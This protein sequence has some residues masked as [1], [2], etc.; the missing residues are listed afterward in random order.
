MITYNTK[1]ARIGR[2]FTPTATETAIED[3]T[4]RLNQLATSL[5][6][7][8]KKSAHLLEQ[9]SITRAQMQRINVA[10]SRIVKAVSP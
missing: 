7:E 6:A 8:L 10:R 3:H 4:I 5:E 1:P 9:P 2:K